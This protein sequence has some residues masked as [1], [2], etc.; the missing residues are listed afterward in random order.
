[1]IEDVNE[2]F[3]GGGDAWVVDLGDELHFQRL[4]GIA[5]WEDDVLQRP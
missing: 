2:D 5:I 3:A 1:M 4:K